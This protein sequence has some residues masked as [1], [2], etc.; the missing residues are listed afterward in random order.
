MDAHERMSGAQLLEVNGWIKTLWRVKDKT[1]VRAAAPAT[2]AE[3]KD[4]R[5]FTTFVYDKCPTALLALP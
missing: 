1:S 4:W 5:S 3:S 2:S